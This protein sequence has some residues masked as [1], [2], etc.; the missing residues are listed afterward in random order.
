MLGFFTIGK[1]A[2]A[3]AC[4]TR[5]VEG[6]QFVPVAI[7][8]SVDSSALRNPSIGRMIEIET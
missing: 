2:K 6:P 5:D 3:M 8:D 1:R 7:S 4:E